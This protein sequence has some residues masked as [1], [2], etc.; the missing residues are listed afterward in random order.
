MMRNIEAFKALSKMTRSSL[1]PHGKFEMMNSF[2]T[3]SG[4]SNNRINGI[5]INHL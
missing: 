4:A 3:S 2:E 1:G 5:L